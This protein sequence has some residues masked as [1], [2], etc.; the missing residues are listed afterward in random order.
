[1]N[2]VTLDFETYY[3]SVYS[4]RKMTTEE[5]IRDP[6]FEAIGVAIS[7]NGAPALFFPKPNIQQ[8][9]ST[10]DWDNSMVI[11]HNM[12]FDGAIL[13]WHYQRF[14]K[15]YAC[16]LSMAR[17]LGLNSQVGG[18]LKALIEWMQARGI[19]VGAKGDEV[20]TFIGKRYADFTFDELNAYSRYCKGDVNGTAKLFEVL[21]NELDFPASELRVI[22][23]VMRLYC[24]PLLTLDSA[25]L[26]SHL[27]YIVQR[28]DNLLTDAGVTMDEIRSDAKFAAALQRYG[29]TPPTKL[30]KKGLVKFAF[31]KTDS[32]FIALQE[33]EDPDVQMLVECRLGNKSTIEESRTS[34][35]IGISSRGS[36]PFPLVYYAAHT[37]RF[38]GGEK[39]NLQN[40][41]RGKSVTAAGQLAVIDGNV[42]KVISVDSETFTTALGAVPI[43]KYG[44][45]SMRDTIMAPAGHVLVVGDSAQIEARMVACVA[46]EMA[47][48][49]GFA[50]GED[51]YSAFASDI[52]GVPVT[53]A[54][55]IRRF[56]GKT[57]ILGLGFGMGGPKFADTLWRG[58]GGLRF[59]MSPQEAGSVVSLYRTKYA[60]IRRLW[61][62][63]NDVLKVLVRGESTS[64]GADGMFRALPADGVEAIPRIILPNG[65]AI[66][67]P[68]L[69]AEQG[70]KGTQ[71]FYQVKE[72]RRVYETKIYGG[73]MVENVVQAAARIVITEQWM[74]VKS[75][76][77][78]ERI[79]HRSPVVGQVHDELICCVP[80]AAAQDME[81]LLLEEMSRPPAWAPTLPVASETGIAVRYGDAK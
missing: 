18:S 7:H 81:A 79:F 32:D 30:N 46:Q 72:G 60:N 70:E 33:H 9:L 35:L 43:K 37:G 8:G 40:L 57:S 3:D 54:D 45:L 48:L 47:L 41:T 66:R 19:D 58:N 75:R 78:K 14:P 51:I 5:Y 50:R 69:R 4:L 68:G 42:A 62:R 22:D 49:A 38:G 26:K 34:R 55:T 21:S 44:Q 77:V 13:A 25:M 53:K 24:D 56:V 2:I 20:H 16:T 10:I 29:I 6:R 1:M 52:F 59:E 61:S 74:R 80:I 28:K 67:Y 11:G 12:M 64:F 63:A 39:I 15:A 73:K 36:L 76:A 27:D 23:E 71:Y 31:S 17:G 65:M